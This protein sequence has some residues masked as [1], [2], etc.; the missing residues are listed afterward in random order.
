MCILTNKKAVPEIVCYRTLPIRPFYVF[1]K[2]LFTLQ[3][4]IHQSL[5]ETLTLIVPTFPGIDSPAAA[6]RALG[7][8]V[9]TY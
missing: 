2:T 7:V 9:L 5:N 6:V 1:H 3:R 8:P 4:D